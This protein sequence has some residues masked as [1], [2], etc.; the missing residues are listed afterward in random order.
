MEIIIIFIK[1]KT[2]GKKWCDSNLTQI[3][4]DFYNDLDN[5]TSNNQRYFGDWVTYKGQSDVGYYLGT[6][7]VQYICESYGFDDVLS[8]DIKEV[9][10]LYSEFME[11]KD[12]NI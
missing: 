4:K 3:K 10:S 12:G 5:M 1:I 6:K 8:F 9:N 2:D 7:F 11:V